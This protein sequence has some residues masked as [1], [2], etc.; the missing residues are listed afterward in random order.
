MTCNWLKRFCSLSGLNCQECHVVRQAGLVKKMDLFGSVIKSTPKEMSAL[1][2]SD[3]VWR[4]AAA[5]RENERQGSI[6]SAGES[7]LPPNKEKGKK[8]RALIEASGSGNREQAIGTSSL[9][10]DL[11]QQSKKQKVGEP[12]CID[13]LVLGGTPCVRPCFQFES[14]L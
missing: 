5:Q 11:E 4:S 14:L 3:S 8:K 7:P 10:G 2:S 6:T 1:F 12:R 13:F 9:E